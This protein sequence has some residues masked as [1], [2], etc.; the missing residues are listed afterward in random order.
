[1]VFLLSP[2]RKEEEN[3]HSF[4]HPYVFARSS[5]KKMHSYRRLCLRIP[6]SDGRQMGQRQQQQTCATTTVCCSFD[7]LYHSYE[8]Q[9]YIWIDYNANNE[10]YS[11]DYTSPLF[12]SMFFN[13]FFNIET[14]A[15]IYRTDSTANR[16][17]TI[18]QSI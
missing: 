15:K 1:V 2:A 10:Q 7:V 12:V 11:S 8:Q 9:N 4:L 18:N 17:T 5:T 13:H 3:H 16:S 14:C 6:M